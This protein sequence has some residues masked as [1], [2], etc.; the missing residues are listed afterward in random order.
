MFYYSRYVIYC[1]KKRTT[2][3]PRGIAQEVSQWYY[4]NV[5]PYKPHSANVRELLHGPVLTLTHKV[6][7]GSQE[8][9]E[10]DAQ[11]NAS[12][13]VSSSEA[14]VALE[15]KKSDVHKGAGADFDASVAGKPKKFW[16]T[17]AEVAET[18]KPL[19]Q[20]KLYLQLENRN[21][22]RMDAFLNGLEIAVTSTVNRS[23]PSSPVMHPKIPKPRI[24][25]VKTK[26]QA[27]LKALPEENSNRQQKN[28]NKNNKSTK[29]VV[30][31][32]NP[33]SPTGS[34]TL[35]PVPAPKK[36]KQ[37]DSSPVL[38]SLNHHGKAL[39][40]SVSAETS[41]TRMRQVQIRE[42]ELRIRLELYLRSLCRV[43][44]LHQLCVVAYEPARAV[45]ARAELMVS[46]FVSTVSC[47]N[48]LSP[49]LTK[50]LTTMTKELLAAEFIGE[51]LFRVIRRMVHEYEHASS[52]ASLSFLS[53]PE[54]AAETRLAPMIA[55]Y[56]RYLQSDW[57]THEREC[58]LERML[59][60]SLDGQMRKYFKTAE[61]KSIGHLLEVCQGFRNELNNIELAPTCGG[62]DEELDLCNDPEAVR[63]ATYD[64]QR[65]VIT[66]NGQVQPAVGSLQE[67]L[68]LLSHSINSK[69][70]TATSD[71]GLVNKMKAVSVGK[72]ESCPSLVQAGEVDNA[73]SVN[74][75]GEKTIKKKN[76]KIRASLHLPTV[77]LL[78]RRLLI[79]AS[80]TGTGGD[81]YFIV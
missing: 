57:R 16:E 73:S 75:K 26:L 5:D 7:Y 61:F 54:N 71:H 23:P 55:K 15:E 50:L 8:E 33:Q 46:A 40:R 53:T 81:A 12:T 28:N 31:V 27:S 45:Q 41:S 77:D 56:I 35:K 59:S 60:R 4:A 34:P 19:Q 70:L 62:L 52:F 67:M 29:N 42:S 47:V 78:T 18:K 24:S 14:V 66:I 63:Q 21:R 80:R 65:E 11:A 25:A 79:A 58:I 64:L 43:R 49:V 32:S 3:D 51:N 13:K 17:S 72:S 68:T 74:E 69:T 48:S 38:T 1:L 44:S 9:R 2:M 6:L 37:F 30:D 76:S 36:K 10:D 20:D 39:L 22:C